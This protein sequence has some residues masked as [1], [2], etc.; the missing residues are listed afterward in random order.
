MRP[1][2]P[3]RRVRPAGRPSA[4]PATAR[5]GRRGLFSERPALLRA[6]LGA[7]AASGSPALAARNHLEPGGE[8]R[9]RA[10]GLL[11][12]AGHGDADLYQSGSAV[13]PLDRGHGVLARGTAPDRALQPGAGPVSWPVVPGQLCAGGP[14]PRPVRRGAA[15][16]SDR[17]RL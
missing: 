3:T 15:L 4:R 8:P 12:R 9:L 6:I 5:A 1:P 17:R 14:P 2:P 16:T 13:D 10:S 11:R 7:D